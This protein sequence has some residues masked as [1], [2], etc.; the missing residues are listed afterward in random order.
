MSFDANRPDLT[1]GVIG[2]GAMGRGIVQ[3]AVAGGINVVM[4][5]SRP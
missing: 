2:T 1:V 4:S 3:V 5:D